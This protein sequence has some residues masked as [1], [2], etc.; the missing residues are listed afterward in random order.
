MDRGATSTMMKQDISPRTSSEKKKRRVQDRDAGIPYFL[1]TV[2]ARRRVQDR[3]DGILY[4]REPSAWSDDILAKL[5]E[6]VEL[7]IEAG[8]LREDHSRVREAGLS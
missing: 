8:R 1:P 4:G 3:D 7:M 6:Q 2:T 5:E